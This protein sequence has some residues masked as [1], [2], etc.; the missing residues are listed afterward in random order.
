[1]PPQ[2]ERSFV[3]TFKMGCGILLAVAL[4]AYGNSFS[5]SF[6]FDDW[7]YL[8]STNRIWDWTQF[9]RIWEANP[10]RFIHFLLYAIIFH[11]CGENAFDYHLVNFV[12]HSINGILVFWLAR[13][14]FETALP[15]KPKDQEKTT[16]IT[17]AALFAALLFISHPIQ[18][19]AITYISQRVTALVTLFY[20]VTLA[21]FLQSTIYRDQKPRREIVFLSLAFL[22]TLLAMFTKQNAFTL[23]IAL[24]LL[25][26]FL[27][28]TL[29]QDRK[30]RL[31]RLA[32]FLCCLA[33]IPILTFG[34]PSQELLDIKNH[35]LKMHSPKEYLLTQF[36]VVVTYLRLLVFPVN[37][38]LD[39]DY[40]ITHRLDLG[41]F[42]SLLFLLG[43]F[44][45]GV[46]AFK[47][48]RILSLGILFF[49][50]A[51]SVES[52]VVPL[53]D[54]IFEHRLYLPAVGIFLAF[55]WVWFFELEKIL[56]FRIPYGVIFILIPILTFAT[57]ERNKVWQSEETLWRDAVTKSPGKARPHNNLAS[58]L[59]S[60]G[61][62]QEA[63]EEAMKTTLL[64][65]DQWDSWGILGSTYFGLEQYDLAAVNLKRAVAIDS[66]QSEAHLLL[67]KTYQVQGKIDEA[68]EEYSIH[69]NQKP[70]IREPYMILGSLLEEKGGY[71]KMVHLYRF[72]IE[73]NPRFVEAH[74]NLGNAYNQLGRPSEAMVE[75]RRAIE[76]DPGMTDAYYN[77]A[78][79]HQ[80]QNQKQTALKL[81][82]KIIEIDPSHHNTYINL[83]VLYFENRENEKS[84]R[85]FQKALE[86]D[87]LNLT[88]HF[89]LGMIHYQNKNYSDSVHHLNRA[90]Q[91]GARVPPQIM[92]ELKPYRKEE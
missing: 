27:F 84:V 10:A 80:L 7:F 69:I 58:A 49:F 85:S 3:L 91:E 63:S 43:F 75:Y 67:A 37:Q 79:I 52:S 25:D 86:F 17:M 57:Y 28:P 60:V 70:F 68:I 38:V 88:A 41:T 53:E 56:P 12:I 48:A 30:K 6:Q 14:L 83:G 59:G 72:G 4:L 87:P 22:S 24:L 42:C 74:Y 82:E 26:Y 33:I 8:R 92:K 9:H 2:E 40:P 62:W 15:S 77:L 81:Y 66:T 90:I 13:F 31:L 1:M 16:K 35:G 45:L 11:F 29:D 47:K 89:N 78:H 55:A 44:S 20:L 39:Y 23:P 46:A 5:A 76:I 32:P 19:Q 65:P 73:N 51:L 18:T 34:L 50:L 54:V 36:H 64:A 21:C 61:R 71:E